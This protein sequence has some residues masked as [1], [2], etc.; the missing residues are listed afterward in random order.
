MY[1]PVA[2]RSAFWEPDMGMGVELKPRPLFIELEWEPGVE[3]TS[4]P[5]TSK[6]GIKSR[7][8]ADLKCGLHTALARNC[9]EGKYD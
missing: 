4:G 2:K 9:I 7:F 3:V 5:G 8:K 1:I 6:D